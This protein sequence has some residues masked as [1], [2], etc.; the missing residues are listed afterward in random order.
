[1]KNW[2]AE[3]EKLQKEIER[4][5]KELEYWKTAFHKGVRL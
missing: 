3:C 4:L 2:K 5:Q 1:M